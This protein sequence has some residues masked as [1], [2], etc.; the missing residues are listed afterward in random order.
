LPADHKLEFNAARVYTMSENAILEE[1]LVRTLEKNR[2]IYESLSEEGRQ[3]VDSHVLAFVNALRG[4]VD[5]CSDVEEIYGALRGI[6]GPN[7]RQ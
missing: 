4:E 6:L 3:S 2:R 1:A 5:A 7:S